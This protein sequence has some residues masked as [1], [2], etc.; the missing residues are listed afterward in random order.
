VLDRREQS[1]RGRIKGREEKRE[2]RERRK[3]CGK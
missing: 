1:K 2:K 3:P